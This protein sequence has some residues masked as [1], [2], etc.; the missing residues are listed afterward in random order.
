MCE[1]YKIR[2]FLPS[3]GGGSWGGCLVGKTGGDGGE[4][5]G[6]EGNEQ[7]I[8]LLIAPSVLPILFQSVSLVTLGS[9]FKIDCAT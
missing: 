4:R 2:G 5:A 3:A 7:M 8:M 1:L 6:E 9:N